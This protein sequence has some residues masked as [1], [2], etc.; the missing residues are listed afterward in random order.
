MEFSSY[1]DVISC[2][3]KTANNNMEDVEAESVPPRPETPAIILYTSGSTGVPKG[4]V[5]THYNLV[6]T[7]I[8]FLCE[9]DAITPAPDDPYI[10]Y[11][12][13][14]LELIGES[15]MLMSGVGHRPQRPQHAH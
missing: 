12:A 7:L 13:H 5:L 15:M 6:A 11:L 14:V 4:V 9:L 1:W 3:K 10:A 2:G 8:S